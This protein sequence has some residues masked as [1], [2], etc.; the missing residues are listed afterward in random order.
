MTTK[1][2]GHCPMGCGQTLFA[3]AGGHITCSHIGC[4]R[5][6][7][8]D[9]LLHDRETEH[10]VEIGQTGFT[11]RHPL[12]ERLDDALMECKL[13]ERIAALSGPPARPGRY[14]VTANTGQFPEGAWHWQELP[15]AKA[16]QS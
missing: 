14:R 6:T 8:V 16:A 1:T 4:K 10:I 15:A 2:A 3:G 11:I 7:A 9:E 12:R 5:P 13:H